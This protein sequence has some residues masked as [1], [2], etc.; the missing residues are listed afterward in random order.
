MNDLLNALGSIVALLGGFAA[1]WWV[2]TP[3]RFPGRRHTR[4]LVAVVF[5]GVSIML[6]AFA[7]NF[8]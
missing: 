3:K 1:M 4:G 6:Y 7:G 8:E 5:F 2:T